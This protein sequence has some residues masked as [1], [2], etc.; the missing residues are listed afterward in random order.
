MCSARRRAFWLPL[1]LAGCLAAAGS[2]GAAGT[3]VKARKPLS[4]SQGER[5]D[6][7]DFIVRG[8]FT[9]FDFTSEYCPPCRAYDEPLYLLHEQ[10]DNVAVVKIDINRSMF[11]KIDW[12]SP[13]AKQYD[14]HSIP[15]FVIYG[16]D[17]KLV[18]ADTAEERPARALVDKMINAL[19]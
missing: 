8:K 7:A 10:R 2:A 6:L 14:L 15:H 17:G 1:I 19:D 18:A 16:P 11:H 13:V 4:I 3:H 5:V 12:D 9:I